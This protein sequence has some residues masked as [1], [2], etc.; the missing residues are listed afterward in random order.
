MVFDWKGQLIQSTLL[1]VSPNEKGE[2]WTFILYWLIFCLLY[3]LQLTKWKVR[4]RNHEKLQYLLPI[5]DFKSFEFHLMR[6]QYAT[7]IGGSRWPSL[8]VPQDIENF[9]CERPPTQTRHMQS[10]GWWRLQLA[11]QLMCKTRD[12]HVVFVPI[13][14][15]V[16]SFNPECLGFQRVSAQFHIVNQGVR[17]CLTFN[18]PS[19]FYPSFLIL[20]QCAY[21]FFSCHPAARKMTVFTVYK[22]LWQG[23]VNS[24]IQNW[25]HCATSVPL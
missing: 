15:H 23:K 5:Y 6:R 21:H 1:G 19:L 11:W 24:T 14:G 16:S 8:P 17:K 2:N 25:V 9:H 20:T 3:L 13:K 7:K 10:R 12:A 18:C 22:S 4:I